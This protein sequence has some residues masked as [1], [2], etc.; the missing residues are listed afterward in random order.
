[1]C[2]V[3][4]KDFLLAVLFNLRR[5]L[6]WQPL[7]IGSPSPSF[8]GSSAVVLHVLLAPSYWVPSPSR[9]TEAP[10]LAF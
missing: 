10:S 4:N 8:T 2:L 6:N 1:M 9:F 7:T 3:S 5:E